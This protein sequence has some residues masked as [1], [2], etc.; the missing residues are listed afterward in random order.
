MSAE[1]AAMDQPLYLVDSA[2][3]KLTLEALVEACAR[4]GWSL[5]AA[6]VRTNHVHIVVEANAMPEKIMKDLKAYASRRLD[7]SGLDPQSRKRWV[8]HGSTRY[9]GKPKQLSTAVRYRRSGQAHGRVRRARREREKPPLADGRGFRSVCSSSE[10]STWPSAAHTPRKQTSS[11]PATSS[12]P[13]SVHPH[14]RPRWW[15]W[16]SCRKP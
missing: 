5:M 4:R 1:R 13:R 14:C 12:A 2:R 7:R 3:R 11:N 10:S 15:I 16:F 9:L 6:H 8:R